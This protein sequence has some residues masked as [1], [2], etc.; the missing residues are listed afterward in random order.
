SINS[1][2]ESTYGAIFKKYRRNKLK[3]IQLQ[4]YLTN[5]DIDTDYISY[6]LNEFSNIDLSEGIKEKLEEE[7]KVLSNKKLS[8]NLIAESISLLENENIGVLDNIKQIAR[9]ISS[10]KIENI[11]SLASRF[12]NIS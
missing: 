4:N 8:E 12:N 1:L 7:Y 11:E 2:V 5:R 9:N 10:V 3:L 6:Q